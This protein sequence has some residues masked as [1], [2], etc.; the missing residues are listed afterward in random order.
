MDTARTPRAAIEAGERTSADVDRPLS[1]IV[2]AETAVKE[3]NN[4]FERAKPLKKSGYLSGATYDQR[5]SASN[6]ADSKLNSA[7]DNLT[8]ARAGPETEAHTPA[9]TTG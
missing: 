7:R 5:E 9:T 3:A 8:S 4:A 6:M 2:Q 1:G